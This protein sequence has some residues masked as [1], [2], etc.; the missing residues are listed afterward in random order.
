MNKNFI[1]FNANQLLK[2]HHN[3]YTSF[4]HKVQ[5]LLFLY[6]FCLNCFSDIN[7]YKKLNPK[8]KGFLQNIF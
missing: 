6:E 2:I 4:L 8:I 7:A 5:Y 1:F 3:N